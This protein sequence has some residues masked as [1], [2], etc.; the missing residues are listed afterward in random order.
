MEG[1]LD[2]WETT[3]YPSIDVPNFC[4]ECG[5]CDL[6]AADALVRTLILI[7]VPAL[8]LTNSR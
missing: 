1:L 3:G 4:R 5:F 7:P 2:L 6:E 8:I